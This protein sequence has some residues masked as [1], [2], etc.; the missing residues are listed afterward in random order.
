MSLLS[1]VDPDRLASAVETLADEVIADWSVGLGRRIGPLVAS[2]DAV[3]LVSHCPEP[4]GEAVG[5]RL[6]THGVRA[7]PVRDYLRGAA[8]AIY[9]KGEALAELRA[10][11]PGA[12]VH[13]FADDLIDLPLLTRAHRGTLVNGSAWSRLICRIACPTV[14]VLP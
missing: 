13:A 3:Y 7:V 14:A 8:G 6:G 5:R 1:R 2:A 11:H 9:D 10:E 12:E 4:L